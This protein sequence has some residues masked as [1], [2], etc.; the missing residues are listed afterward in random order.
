MK[1]TIGWFLVFFLPALEAAPF[2]I[3]DPYPGGSAVLPETFQIFLD[4]AQVPVEQPV[5]KDAAGNL[6]VRWDV[7]TVTR[8]VH[9][10]TAKFCHS[11]A[12]CSKASVP[13]SWSTDALGAPAGLKLLPGP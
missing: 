11:V 1:R 6:M 13:F 4:S 2:I 10:V 12:G 9:T 5:Y 7:A 8:G 3:S